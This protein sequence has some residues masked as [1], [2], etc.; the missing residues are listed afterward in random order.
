M[1]TDVHLHAENELFLKILHLLGGEEGSD[2][3]EG[4]FE[5]AVL[6]QLPRSRFA[7]VKT[8]ADLFSLRSDAYELRDNGCIRLVPA[9]RGVP[10]VVNLSA[11]YKLVDSLDRLGVPSLVGAKSL[12]IG[13]NLE[14]AAGVAVEGEV[15]LVNSF[16]QTARVEPG[17][18]RDQALEFGDGAWTERN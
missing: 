12:T 8:T 18:L 9:R 5:I 4:G 17:V 15:R 13:G 2:A 10:P 1:K 7:P 6:A 3:F 16:E 11:Q 14:F